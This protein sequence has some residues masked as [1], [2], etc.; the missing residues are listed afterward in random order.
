MKGNWG[1]GRSRMGSGIR[2][3]VG[4]DWDVLVAR[5]EWV[6]LCSSG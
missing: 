3:G 4:S 2:G 1:E 6:V 5:L